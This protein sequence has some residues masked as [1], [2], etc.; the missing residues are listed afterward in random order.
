MAMPQRQHNQEIPKM[1]TITARRQGNAIAQ[2]NKGVP[3][4]VALLL[5][6]PNLVSYGADFLIV[7]ISPSIGAMS[8]VVSS[9]FES[10]AVTFM[11]F[12]L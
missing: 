5:P 9:T 8:A 1:H 2:K 3:P 6:H 11:V 12:F 10:R 7:H 4:A